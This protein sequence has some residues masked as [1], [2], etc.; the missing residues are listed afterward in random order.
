MGNILMGAG[1]MDGK[2]HFSLVNESLHV[3]AN[4]YHLGRL[5][6][7]LFSHGFIGR[8]PTLNGGKAYGNAS[9]MIPPYS[10]LGL[11]IT[12]TGTSGYE[13]M[14]YEDYSSVGS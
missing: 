14:G 1:T 12:G 11:V 13:S 4:L 5:R 6:N 3:D 8:H 9:Q 7:S 10:P 2:T